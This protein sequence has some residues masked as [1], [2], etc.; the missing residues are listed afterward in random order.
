[1][2][3]VADGKFAGR[4]WGPGGE[5]FLGDGSQDVCAEV[6]HELTPFWPRIG[7]PRDDAAEFQVHA[8]R[9][10]VELLAGSEGERVLL[11]EPLVGAVDD[12]KQALRFARLV[13]VSPASVEAFLS[14]A[15]AE[16]RALLEQYR[17][18]VSAL[19]DCLIAKRTM[20]GAEVDAV[21]AA[22]LAKSDLEIEHRRRAAWAKVAERARIFEAAH[23]G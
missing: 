9:R 17:D 20:T 5:Q 10:T 23:H 3:V 11:E 13:C 4:V 12:N 6:I 1:V 21:L 22:A 18:L 19:A 8:I 2:T 14:Y 15:A 16:A 7:E